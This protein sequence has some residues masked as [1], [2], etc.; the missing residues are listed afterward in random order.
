MEYDPSSYYRHKHLQEKPLPSSPSLQRLCHKGGNSKNVILNLFQHLV[1]SNG[2][3]TLKRDQGN[4][5]TIAT[6]SLC[7]GIEVRR[8]GE[9]HCRHSQ[10]TSET[11]IRT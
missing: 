1:N 5:I 6:Q 4:K 7:G 3:E 10:A 8:L 2:Y 9:S 11:S